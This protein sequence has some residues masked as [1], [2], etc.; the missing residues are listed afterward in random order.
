M[1][2]F[3]RTIFHDRDSLAF[4]RANDF[5]A[6]MT[7]IAVGAVALET[8]EEL[9]PYRGFFLLIEYAVVFIFTCEYLGRIVAASKPLKY[10]TSFFGIID[11]LAILPTLVGLTNLSF[12][13]SV[14]VLRMVRFLRLFRLLRILHDR[15]ESQSLQKNDDEEDIHSESFWLKIEIYIV[16]F[17][18]VALT[19]A[20][21]IWLVEGSQETFK[22]I[23]LAAIWS[24]KIL[25]GG[26]F[27]EGAQTVVGELIVI[28]TRFLGLI[29][30]GLLI[31]IV[32]GALK[33]ILFGK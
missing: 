31:N 14:R 26:V 4:K 27:S 28:T 23:P 16:L 18:M 30:F 15:I 19:S 5:F 2:K 7:V 9:S 8:V 11:L 33:K 32:G 3:L 6:W 24:T 20:A 1:Q 25:L 10:M 13:K 12:L 17:V 29:L 21:A 22:N